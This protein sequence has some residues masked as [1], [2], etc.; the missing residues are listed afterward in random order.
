MDTPGVRA[1]VVGLCVCIA[2][3]VITAVTY[4]AASNGGH[5]IVAWGAV[6]FGGLQFLRGVF[7]FLKH[8]AQSPADK[9]L[10]NTTAA[11]RGLVGAMASVVRKP[12]EPT[13]GE[14]AAIA[15]VVQKVA[16]ATIATDTIRRVSAALPSQNISSF[17]ASKSGEI[18]AAVKE[19]II[20]GC[21]FVMGADGH[22]PEVMPTLLKIGNALGMDEA[23]VN[24]IIQAILRPAQAAEAS[25]GPAPK[26]A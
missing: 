14:C 20:Q 4:S 7:E 11:Y 6:L 24:R 21:F 16:N 25:A 26:P 19:V 17:L 15:A 9:A 8:S 12:G 5:Y 3:I 10:A 23:K 1:M 13:P 18:T 2:G 22:R